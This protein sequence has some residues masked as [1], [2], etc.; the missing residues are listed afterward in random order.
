MM[1]DQTDPAYNTAI[2]REIVKNA[3]EHTSASSISP[4]PIIA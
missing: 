2:G 4:G 3:F 1:Q